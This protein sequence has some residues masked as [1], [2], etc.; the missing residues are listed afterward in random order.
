MQGEENWI[1]WAVGE[2]GAIIHSDDAGNSW[3]QQNSNT[4]NTLYSVFFVH[5]NVGCA[6]G[7]YA[8][9]A[10]TAIAGE[11][12]GIKQLQMS[13]Y[14]YSVFFNFNG[15]IAGERGRILY[16]TD[17]F[18]T[19][20]TQN[21]DDSYH[22][23]DIHLSDPVSGWA[24]GLIG[25]LL[26][27][28]NGL[29]WT[30]FEHPEKV[31]FNS[32]HS[33][34]V[35]TIW[36]VGLGGMIYHRTSGGNWI[37]Q[38]SGTYNRLNSVYFTDANNGW[39]VGAQG[40]I[41]HTRDGG[42]SWVMQNSGTS[43]ELHEVFFVDPAI[44]WI[45]GQNGTVLHTINGGGNSSTDEHK[46]SNLDK[47]ILDQQGTLDTLIINLLGKQ[48]QNSILA[49]VEVLID[50]VIHTSTG[51]LEFTLAHNDISDTLIYHAGGDGDN[52][53]GTQLTDAAIISISDTAAPF[54]GRFK[55]YNL[56]SKF[57][58]LDPNGE[59]ILRVYDST[60][61]N[62]GTLKAWGLKFFYDVTTGI[63]PVRYPIPK[64]VHLQQNYPNPFNPITTI[65]F[66]LPKAGEVNLNIYNILGE[67]IQTLV[68][69]TLH[70]GQH[71]YQ[72]DASQF[73]SGIYVYV[74][75]TKH[76]QEAKKMILIK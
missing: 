21:S 57:A 7:R 5:P 53:I 3:I 54:T 58:G 4:L 31:K 38:E 9:I 29:S 42:N 50:S 33:I 69:K 15:W 66:S 52:F 61:D 6:V 34:D 46:R 47:A 8:T 17:F 35:N 70:A 10:R 43:N 75:Q 14:F 2:S 13:H 55:P 32:V 41:L 62:T 76:S 25:V 18:E 63:D 19:Y 67:K 65:S 60:S 11:S 51:D 26:N 37:E 40:T 73:A 22:L 45:V 1:G 48:S 30:K 68:N 44:G 36:A 24:V 39:A 20:T 49:S 59:W 74:L 72:W 64:E 27:T 71:Y 56:L 16:S 28:N 12:W 23:Y